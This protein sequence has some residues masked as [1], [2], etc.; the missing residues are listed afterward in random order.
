MAGA[1]L[2]FL[3]LALATLASVRDIQDPPS[4]AVLESGTPVTSAVTESDPIVATAKLAAGYAD[5]PVRGRDF[6]VRIPAA[7]P[8]TVELKSHLFDAYLVL[9]DSSGNVLAEDDDGLLGRHARLVIENAAPGDELRIRAC[10]LHGGTGEFLLSL[11]AGSPPVASEL[12]RRAHLLEDALERLAAVEAARGPDHVETADCLH[13]AALLL[14]GDG[15]LSEARS[16]FERALAI[17]EKRLGAEHPVTVESLHTLAI[18]LMDERKLAEARLL[19]ERSLAIR[20][21]ILGPEHGDTAVSHGQLGALLQAQGEYAAA[22][23]HLER[24]AVVMERAAGPDHLYTATSL[25]NW[26]S[27]MTDM[28]DFEA[29]RRLLGRALEIYEKKVG[30]DHADVAF[31]LNMLGRACQHQGDLE[32]ARAFYS[33]ALSIA[34]RSL[35]PEHP[36]TLLLLTN[37]AGISQDC[38]D[39]EVARPVFE[40]VLSIR[41]KTLGRDHPGTLSS[42]VNLASLLDSQGNHDAAQ[43]LYERAL[44]ISEKVY[45][46]NHPRTALILNNWGVLHYEQ[47]NFDAARPLSER[48][49]AIFE[50][51]LGPDHPDTASCLAGLGLLIS[52]GG[53]PAA[54]LPVLERAVAAAERA[55]GPEH[56]RTATALSSL[57]GCFGQLGNYEAARRSSERA[58]AILD[59]SLG[60]CHDRSTKVRLNH[61]L[62]MFARGEREGAWAGTEVAL[63]SAEEA[64]R[65][66]FVGLSEPERFAFLAMLRPI[67]EAQLSLAR[68]LPAREAA[69][70]ERVLL[71]K[72]LVSRS[73]VASRKAVEAQ[74][75]PEA[76]RAI[77][78]LQSTQSRLSRLISAPPQA[79][80]SESHRLELAELREKRSRL[81]RE[82]VGRFET[83]RSDPSPATT[84]LAAALAPGQVLV[85]FFVHR[86]FEPAEWKEGSP[87]NGGRWTKDRVTAWVTRPG[88]LVPRRIDLGPAAPL[89]DAVRSFLADMRGGPAA[90]RGISA[91]APSGRPK[92]GDANDRLREALYDPLRPWI[93][94][95]SLVVVSPDGFLGT[96]PLG[97][98]RDA[99]GTYLIERASFVTLQ[100]AASLGS[101]RGGAASGRPSLLLAGGIDYGDRS[102]APDA[103]AAARR[104]G[105]LSASLDVAWEPL[106]FTGPEALSIAS[107]HEREFGGDESATRLLLEK[108]DATEDRIK[109]ELPRHSHVHLATHGYF[110][111][112]GLRSLWDEARSLAESGRGMNEEAR[113]LTGFLPG[114]LSGLVLT[115]ANRADPANAEDGLLTAEEVSWL[116]LSR[117]EL[118]VL[119][120]C[121]SG[122]GRAQAGEGMLG[123]RRAFRQSGARAVVSSLWRVDDETTAELMRGFYEN[124]WKR[125]QGTLEALRNAQLERLRANRARYAGDGVPVTWGAFVLDGDWR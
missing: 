62:L 73:L 107:I 26:A 68:R 41:E 58:L 108:K 114:L 124:L 55:L 14:K 76:R 5:A 103:V 18:T 100:D 36:M 109:A 31:I 4:V 101:I 66:R 63:E 52:E 37:L 112:E 116:D 22:A 17:R 72:G 90:A 83:S 56:E 28:G 38:G 67:L 29:A 21:K 78:E 9:E 50:T 27:C 82:I 113:R 59:A 35:G 97:A 34:E 122:L 93:E 23:K 19:F 40:R 115:G 45:G 44:A 80:D 48:A 3:A 24:A 71:W 106:P 79:R 91:T 118:V 1:R 30:P 51:T 88:D 64:A 99:D 20:E 32:A 13:A 102:G 105:G 96:V 84:D 77:A 33:R 75:S 57:A 2:D 15:R 39:Y 92:E 123:L 70:Y 7:G 53:D 81:E 42:L 8:Y 12:E 6:L 11:T 85:D 120:A 98:L 69:A 54:A 61:V 65:R 86:D 16:Y 25:A 74:A 125:K 10:A 89:E 111:P 49:L 60:S 119:S 95:A 121:D 117:C 104:S 47:G 43:P 46:A 110:Q 94:G 87:G